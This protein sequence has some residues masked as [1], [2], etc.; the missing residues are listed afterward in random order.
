MSPIRRWVRRTRRNIAACDNIICFVVHS[1]RWQHSWR[2]VTIFCEVE[3]WI[4]ISV[5][6]SL[7]ILLYVFCIFFRIY[8]IY[9]SSFFFS[10][11]SKKNLF[12]AASRSYCF[13]FLLWKTI[14]CVRNFTFS[15]ATYDNL[16]IIRL[17]V[18]NQPRRHNS[19][20][21]IL[22]RLIVLCLM[23]ENSAFEFIFLLFFYLLNYLHSIHP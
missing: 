5:C 2:I 15:Y 1:G 19:L 22:W 8:F 9:S 14:P 4:I 16:I 3:F 11:F 12:I 17:I 20:V 13:L 7:Y 10:N 21:K 18:I 6:F 23:E